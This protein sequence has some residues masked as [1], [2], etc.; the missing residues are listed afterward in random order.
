MYFKKKNGDERI[1]N[2]SKQ[3]GYD[4][5]KAVYKIK[6]DNFGLEITDNGN[7]DV[8]YF[9]N[10]FNA[11]SA[12]EFL[13]QYNEREHSAIKENKNEKKL[14]KERKKEKCRTSPR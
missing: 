14:I 4:N 5:G 13:K 7:S 11:E 6:G 9:K 3:T 1:E 12:K 2:I 10:D 8:F